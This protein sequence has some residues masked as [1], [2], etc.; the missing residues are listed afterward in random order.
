[1]LQSP[2]NDNLQAPLCASLFVDGSSHLRRLVKKVINGRMK[3]GKK[4][5]FGNGKDGNGTPMFDA[6]RFNVVNFFLL[7]GRGYFLAHT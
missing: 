7:H 1:M 5:R 6:M 2:L 4:G 3:S